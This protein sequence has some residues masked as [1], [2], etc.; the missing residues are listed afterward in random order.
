M[1]LL[2]P[3]PLARTY[4]PPTDR[5]GWEQVQLYHQ[6]QRYPDDWGWAR[7]ASAIN[8]DN[9]Q[10][11]DNLSRSN[12]RAW[13][14][15][16]GKPDAARA[17]D[18]AEN[19]GWLAD[20]WTPVTRALAQLV[21]GIFSCGSVD[22]Q[23]WVPGWAVTRSQEIIAAALGQVGVG[24][25][26]VARPEQPGRRTQTSATRLDTRPS[27]RGRRRTGRRQDRRHRGRI[28]RL[29]RRGTAVGAGVVRGVAC[30]RAR[31]RT[32]G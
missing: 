28:A 27:A 23:G 31:V 11:F 32:R 10:P 22:S 30:R 14:E 20:E 7:V 4:S 12:I 13:V 16:D 25:T 8:S 15:G 29:A 18:V 1:P 19:L 5:N 2:S 9:E 17:V 3:Q 26:W 21:A 6:T 24:H